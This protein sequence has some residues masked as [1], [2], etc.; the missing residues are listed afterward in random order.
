MRAHHIGTSEHLSS[1]AL[2][3]V[4]LLKQKLRSSFRNHTALGKRLR[5]DKNAYQTAAA[6]KSSREM[7]RAA[8]SHRVGRKHSKRRPDESD[9]FCRRFRFR[10]RL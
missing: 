7:H 3:V 10:L 2:G 6:A 4:F 9:R 8:R 5:S 1:A